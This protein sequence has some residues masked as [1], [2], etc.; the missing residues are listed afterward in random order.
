MYISEKNYITENSGK[1]DECQDIPSICN[2]I[3][4]VVRII[5]VDMNV[6]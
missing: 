1:F 2:D 5:K 3:I 6:N 4:Q